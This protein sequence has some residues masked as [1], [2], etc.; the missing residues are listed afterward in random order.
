LEAKGFLN[1]DEH[2]ETGVGV[3]KVCSTAVPLDEVRQMV[4]EA[5]FKHVGRVDYLATQAAKTLK[6]RYRMGVLMNNLH[7][8]AE[9]MDGAHAVA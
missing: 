9:I 7:R 5:F 2:W 4:H 1:V 3:S 8:I 6:S